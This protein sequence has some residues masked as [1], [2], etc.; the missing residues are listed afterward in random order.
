MMKASKQCPKCHSLKVGYLDTVIDRGEQA[1]DEA[2]VGRTQLKA[3]FQGG[4]FVGRFEAYVC[5]QCG[6]YETYVKDPTS[7]PFDSIQGFRWINESH[8]TERPPH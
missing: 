1:H 5:A 8:G 7:I 4:E 6:Y 2:V 3:W